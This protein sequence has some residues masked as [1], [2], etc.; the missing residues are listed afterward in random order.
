MSRIATLALAAACFGGLAAP[1]AAESGPLTCAA[2]ADDAV[3]AAEDRL[4]LLVEMTYEAIRARGLAPG[5]APATGVQLGLMIE[6]LCREN[7]ARPLAS[8]V[9]TAVALTYAPQT[10]SPDSPFARATDAD[11]AQRARLALQRLAIYEGFY[12]ARLR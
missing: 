9:E 6:Q 8:A 2:S 10:A 5:V 12:K 4:E 3:I 1:A 11:L 7:P